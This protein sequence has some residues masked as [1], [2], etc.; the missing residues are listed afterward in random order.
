LAPVF[1]SKARAIAPFRVVIVDAVDD[2]N[3][4]AANAVLKT[5]EEPPEKGVLLLV[6]HAPG[7][8]LPTIRSRCRRLAFPPWP[9]E[10]IA[11]F[12]EARLRLDGEEAGRLAGM[13]RGAPG[14]ALTLHAAGV[15]DV[16]ATV[17]ELIEALPSADLPSLAKLA[18]GLRGAEAVGRFG[19][20]MDRLGEAA[21]ERA[22]IGRGEAAERWVRA[23]TRLASLHRQVEGLNSDRVEAFWAAIA[24]LR[25]AAEAA[26]C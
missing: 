7:R 26:P 14:R 21:R 2:M 13:I 24:E 5:L 1:F 17:R 15:L 8:L 16:D 25:A 11:A 18:D 4:A 22:E 3:V 12:A 20:L 6:S 19:L 23:W 10:S 9:D